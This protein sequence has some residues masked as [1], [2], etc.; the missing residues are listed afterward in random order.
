[1]ASRW[2]TPVP[3]S[4]ARTE[5]PGT[6][7]ASR[8]FE[9]GVDDEEAE[10]LRSEGLDPPTRRSS[11]RS[12]LCGGTL[13]FVSLRAPCEPRCTTIGSVDDEAIEAK[14][15]ET[16]P[17]LDDWQRWG[18]KAF[19]PEQGSELEVDDQD[20]PP[21]PV[22][23]IAHR[24]LQVAG[25]HLLAVRAHIEARRLFP[26]SDRTLCRSALLGAAQAVWVLAPEEPG[27]RLKRARTV[28]VYEHRKNRQYLRDLQGIASQPHQNTDTVAA[29]VDS[30]ANELDQKRDAAGE[31]LE[32]SNT[33]M[34]REAVE[35]VFEA[36][37]GAEAVVVWQSGSGA[38][39]GF[40]MLGTAGTVQSSVAD[41]AGIAE[42]Q[43]GGS[44]R[45]M[46]NAYFAAFHTA[47]RGWKLLRQRGTAPQVSR[48]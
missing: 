15:R 8:G 34:I 13:A 35:A 12:T 10:A 14:L 31:R 22:S 20:W 41:Q 16:F 6:V 29:V 1:M 28:A 21:I 46:S 45:R 40:V 38:A 9:P 30:H 18:L 32:L 17:I 27:L 36:A 19:W 48:A 43:V 42:F 47:D 25:D 11:P 23:Q 39:H 44:L 37:H 7:T 5:L 2:W 26:F 4:N 33:D 24:G 3:T